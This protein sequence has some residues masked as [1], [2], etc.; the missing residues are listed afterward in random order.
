MFLQGILKSF[1]IGSDLYMLL[2]GFLCLNKEFSLKF[3]KSGIKVILSYLFFSV[4]TIAVKKYYFHYDLTWL[5]GFMG[6]LSFDTIPYAW[7]IEMWIGLFLMAPFI[8]LLYKAIPSRKMKQWL[9]LILFLLTAP[10]DFANRY[11]MYLFPAFWEHMYPVMF[12]LAGCYIREYRPK[13]PKWKLTLCILG[14]IVTEPLFN[15]A[16]SHPT[17]IQILGDRNG[18]ACV[19]LAILLFLSFYDV[20]LSSSRARLAFETISLRS[21]DIF[22]CSSIFDAA[23]YPFFKS[24]FYENQPQFGIYALAIIPCIFLLSFCIASAKRILFKT[25]ERCASTIRPL[26]F[27][28]T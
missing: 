16:V 23:I 24:R 15:L 28:L 9:I 1:G 8:N 12:Y 18:I 20:R 4:L 21:L 26:N 11:G 22:L 27:K 7:Y 13:F 10:P 25:I 19:P 5:Q 17:Y 2:T 3:Y 6:I 14:I